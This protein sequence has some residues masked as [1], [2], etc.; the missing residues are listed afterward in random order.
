MTYGCAYAVAFT[1]TN[2]PNLYQVYNAY[3]TRATQ[4]CSTGIKGCC[5]SGTV[6]TKLAQDTGT[7][8]NC[9]TPLTIPNDMNLQVWDAHR[10]LSLFCCTCCVCR[11]RASFQYFRSFDVQ[12]HVC[13]RCAS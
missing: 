11:M 1:D 6:L 4:A 5:S 10:A 7:Q 8:Y 3:E 9:Y 12:S 13:M 2:S